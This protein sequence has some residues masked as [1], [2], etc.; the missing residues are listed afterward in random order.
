VSRASISSSTLAPWEAAALVALSFLALMT[1]GVRLAGHGL[2]GTVLGEVL[3]VLL[4]TLAF[5]AARRLPAAAVGFG[6]F[7]L[8]GVI[9]GA[10]F[11][12]AA[13]Y[14]VAVALHAWVE[15]V[16]P[17]PPEV[18]RSLERMVVPVSGARP[19]AL[20]LVAF[21]LVPAAA[22]ELLFRGVL[23]SAVRPR[24]GTVGAVVATAVA[25]GLYHG[26]LYRLL[27][28]VLG[29][30]LL[31]GVRAA[32]GSL[33]PALAFHVANNAAVV[34]ALHHGWEAPP[35]SL[36]PLAGAAAAT[37]AG[38]TAVVRSKA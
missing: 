4:P 13:F 6:R 34:V 32:S 29:G 26:S 22:E 35:P 31:G 9:G 37:V 12:A 8:L 36:L 27:P 33:W 25:F 38:L 17:T 3:C 16:W 18:R 11:G 5:V 10:L 7:P 2:G 24:L 15:H 1:V 21:A 28:A 30:L 20:D 19:L 14:L 23:Y